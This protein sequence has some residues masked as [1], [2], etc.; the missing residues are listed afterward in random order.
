MERVLVPDAD[1]FRAF[2]RRCQDGGWQRDCGGLAVCLEPPLPGCAVHQLKVGAAGGT[3]TGVGVWVGRARPLSS[4]CS[5][6]CR[7]DIPDVAAGTVYDVLHDGEYRCQ[8]DTNVIACHD[9]AR[10]AAN[11]N[12]GY[13]ACEWGPL[14]PEPLIGPILLLFGAWLRVTATR[15]GLVRGR[16]TGITTP[17]PEDARA[18]QEPLQWLWAWGSGSSFLFLPPL[19]RA[20]PKALKEQ[21]RGDTAGLAGRGRLS[22][23]HQLLGQAP[24]ECW[25]GRAGPEIPPGI[26]R[27]PQSPSRVGTNSWPS[28]QLEAAPP[29]S[30]LGV[31]DA[32]TERERAG[33]VEDGA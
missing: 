25:G 5:P 29:A 22:H 31:F 13:Y 6:Q 8:W 12:V 28:P 15:I 27:D 4:G 18:G 32:K 7:I 26:N 11:A 2:Q 17:A 3:G 30:L 23:H 10:V 33:R 14:V 1:A 9:I 24:G 21:G 19:S 16:G 20:L